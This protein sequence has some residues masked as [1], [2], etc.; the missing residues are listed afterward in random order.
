MTRAN[1]GVE[2]AKYDVLNRELRSTSGVY[3]F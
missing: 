3:C 1:H 2:K